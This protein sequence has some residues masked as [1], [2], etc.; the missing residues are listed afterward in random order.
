LPALVAFMPR[1][2]RVIKPNKWKDEEWAA[3]G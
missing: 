1:K 3:S 2:K